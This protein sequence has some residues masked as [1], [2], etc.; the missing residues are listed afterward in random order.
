MARTHKE[1]DQFADADNTPATSVRHKEE[2]KEE[3]ASESEPVLS[4]SFLNP[5]MRILSK[6]NMG[7]PLEFYVA[8]LSY[9]LLLALTLLG[10]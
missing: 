6:L 8:K 5:K 1:S 4:K 10:S 2:K 3:I 7:C 9:K